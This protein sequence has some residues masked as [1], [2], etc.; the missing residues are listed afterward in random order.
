VWVE[1]QKAS[2]KEKEERKQ[3]HTARI[4]RDLAGFSKV[5]ILLE[6]RMI[7]KKKEEVV[8]SI[9]CLRPSWEKQVMLAYIFDF[10]MGY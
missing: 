2:S 5:C 6:Y 9:M 1:T 3:V 7:A 10:K 4:I 8:K